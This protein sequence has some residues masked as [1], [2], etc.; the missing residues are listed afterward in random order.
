[1]SIT[2]TNWPGHSLRSAFG[3]SPFSNTV[4]LVV[5]TALSMNASTPGMGGWPSRRYAST[6]TGPCRRA[7]ATAGNCGSGRAKVTAIGLTWLITASGVTALA[8]T[9]LPWFTSSSPTRPSSGEKMVVYPSCTFAEATAALSTSTAAWAPSTA[10]RAASSSTPAA[11]PPAVP[12]R[13]SNRWA[14]L[15]AVS[16]FDCVASASRTAASYARGSMVNSFCPFV[17]VSPSLK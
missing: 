10:V 2:S 1:M 4:P 5:F 11:P 17:T 13:S 6:L 16:L 9:W 7:A 12:S 14:P 15:R 8:S 3:N